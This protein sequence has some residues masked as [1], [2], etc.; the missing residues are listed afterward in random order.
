MGSSIMPKFAIWSSKKHIASQSMAGVSL[1][2]P[3]RV[4]CLTW[5]T[6]LLSYLFNWRSWSRSGMSKFCRQHKV[7]L[8]VVLRLSAFS[9][10]SSIQAACKNHEC[11]REEVAGVNP[12]RSNRILSRALVSC[13]FAETCEAFLEALGLLHLTWHRCILKLGLA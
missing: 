8:V 13:Y 5:Y 4:H 6:L 12:S 2:Q 1:Y 3:S 7:T 11:I 9:I 10:I